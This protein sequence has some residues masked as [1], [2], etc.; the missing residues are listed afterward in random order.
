[1][2]LWHTP[3][4]QGQ[5]AIC[6]MFQLLKEQQQRKEDGGAYGVTDHVGLKVGNDVSQ[7]N[8]TI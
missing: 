8:S 6:S 2:L 7:P 1:M 5:G 4:I 3:L